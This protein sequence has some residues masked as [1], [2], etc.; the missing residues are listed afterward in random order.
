L[1]C[2]RSAA[3]LLC[4]LA[5]AA[6]SQSQPTDRPWTVEEIAGKVE[7]SGG[8]A[9]DGLTWSP[10]GR[11]L[12]LFDDND[13]L[14]A[15]DPETGRRTQLFSAA[16]LNKVGTRE[17]NEKDR[18]HRTRYDQPEFLWSP[19]GEKILIDK[20]GELWLASLKGEKLD[21]VGDSE[22]GSGDD[23]KFSPD[24]RLLSYVH[25][26]NLYALDLGKP[27]TPVA[28]THDGTSS[29]LNGEVDWVYL[30][31]LEVRS[32]SAWS[33]DS[34]QLAYL[35]MNESAVPEYPIVDWIGT[36]S[37]VDEQRYPQPGD[38]N[39]AVRVGVVAAAG[40]ETRWINLPIRP[41][42]DYIPRFGWAAPGVL[43]IETM[44]RD[45]QHK[46]IYFAN[47]ATGE[48]KL[49]L[50][51]TD[52][53]YFDDKYDVNF[54]APGEFLLT[55]WQDGYR[56]IY[57]FTYDAADPLSHPAAPGGELE[58]G[59][60]DVDKVLS[61]DAAT[62]GV[63]YD[64]NESDDLDK[65]VWVVKLDGS[66]KHQV[67][68]AA[69]TH[70]AD[71]AAGHDRFVD[72]SSSRTTPRKLA[73]CSGSGA[74]KT[75]FEAGLPK[76]HVMR[77]TKVL[78]LKAADGVTTLYATLL[79]PAG[80]AAAGSVPLINNPYGGPGS[81]GQ[82]NAW[83]GRTFYFDQLLA[84]HGF[85]VMHMDNRDGARRGRD[86]AQAA[87]RDFGP[88]QL[89]DQLA[90]IDQVLKLYPQLDPKRLGWWGWSWGGTFT[91]NAMTHSDRFKAGVAVAPVTDFRL[92]DSIYTERYLGLPAENAKAYGAA[93][94]L[95]SAKNLSGHLLIAHGT[96]DDNVHIANT[97]NFVQELIT[98]NKPYDL[99]IFPRK[100]HSIAGH[101]ARKELYGRIL[102]QFE[103][104]LK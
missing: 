30:E 83:S 14:V 65:Q 81:A 25:G 79:L 93:S 99:Q 31:E 15:V 102:A 46:D 21:K 17:V 62:R 53:R 44:A 59:S 8:E 69:G 11:R 45:Q 24:G 95:G 6:F 86:F 13:D 12:A 74:C 51:Q 5:S 22:Q 36:H 50:A 89:A 10:D 42:Q 90:A 91:L 43:W 94:V 23:P 40:G 78:K 96:G 54:Y 103:T 82:Q 52:A 2:P 57:R 80:S 61:V 18:D 4:L 48:A 28:L 72:E 20:D 60:Y 71:F 55:G 33:P 66:G 19:D 73:L 27:G 63:Y 87:Y 9:P 92:Y 98:A 16:R 41:G 101:D 88:V 67:T 1:P 26:H 104:Y 85:A 34:K 84:E 47:A 97:V 76:N 29:L 100:T 49:A 39:P 77:E 35:Q 37:S 32:N 75:I 7:T 64:S 38:P 56:H 3:L 68:Q 58:H 70:N